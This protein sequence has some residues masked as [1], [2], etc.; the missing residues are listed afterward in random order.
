MSS[1]SM[2]HLQPNTTLQGGKYRIER[3]LGQGGFS[4]IYLAVQKSDNRQVVIKELFLNGEN[5]RVGSVIQ[6]SI[7]ANDTLFEKQKKKFKKEAKRIMSLDNQ[8]IVK[9]Y[10]LFEENNTVYYVMDYVDGVTLFDLMQR[11]GTPMT[12]LEVK[13]LL[14]QM[15]DALKSIHNADILHLDLK[16]MNIMINKAGKVVIIGFDASIQVN[17]NNFSKVD[18]QDVCFTYGYAPREQIELEFDKIGPWT[19]IYAFGATLYTLLTNKCPPSITQ[20]DNDESEDK[21]SSLPLYNISKG[22]KNL[23]LLMMKTNRAQRPQNIDELSFLVQKEVF[24]IDNHNMQHLQ[25]NTTLQGGKYRIERALGQGGFGITYLAVQEMLNRKVAIKEFFMREYCD[26]YNDNTSI[27]TNT[28]AAHDIVERFKKKFISE[29]STIAKFRHPNIIDIYDVF[30]ENNTA[31]YVMEYI[32]GESLENV[33]KRQ[34]ALSEVAAIDYI[35]QVGTALECMHQQKINHLDV[36]PANIMLRSNKKEVVLIDFGISKL[37]DDDGK[38]LTTT[39][40]GVSEGYAPIEQY[41][42]GSLKEFSPQTDIYALGATLYKLVIGRTPPSIND[43]ICN[44]LSFPVKVSSPV[45]ELIKN[46]MNINRN[47]RPSSITSF[48]QPLDTLKSKDSLFVN[49]AE[50]EST[51]AMLGGKPL[52]ESIAK[53]LFQYDDCGDVY[54]SEGLACVY[55]QGKGGY[56]DMNGLEVIPCAF[57]SVYPFHHEMARVKKNNKYGWINKKG[58]V[59]IPIIYD[60]SYYFWE[61]MAFVKKGGKLGCIDMMGKEV[62]PFVYDDVFNGFC[63]GLASVAV[64]EKWGYIDN[65][66]K[67][68]ITYIYDYATNFIDGLAI[69]QKGNKY[70]CIDEEGNEVIPIGK[71]ECISG[72]DFSLS[73][74]GLTAVMMNGKWG[75]C[76]KYG[77]VIV[78]CIYDNVGRFSEGFAAVRKVN[79]AYIN[80]NGYPITK[81][82]FPDANTFEDGYAVVQNANRKYGVVDTSFN[83]LIP[84]EYQDII[85]NEGFTVKKNGKW[86]YVNKNKKVVHPCIYDDWIFFNEGIAFVWKNGVLGCVDK[87]GRSSFDYL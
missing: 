6:V 14:P 36:K 46:A 31:Y 7:S 68:V 56:I 85:Y 39:L 5:E 50:S 18:E 38:E 28:P 77:N 79:W 9:V 22:M 43:I 72:K 51:L 76:D 32:E 15:L 45:E 48:L 29:A 40:V 47:Q 60:Y 26:R 13:R 80:K 70:G 30:L 54:I 19:D 53:N 49:T 11:T 34:G 78:P 83:E 86:G 10:D 2:Q 74:E 82:E 61:G 58:N 27:S 67:V 16:P 4:I 35:R 84:F 33:V 17:I 52:I 25:P 23:I 3:V 21:H 55:R 75:Y 73:K 63:G 64:D 44:G 87:E 41:Q 81:F 12:E 42:K 24:G 8:H 69:V 71:Y 62:I 65:S 66:G 57:E 59:I 1:V 20:I 37:Y